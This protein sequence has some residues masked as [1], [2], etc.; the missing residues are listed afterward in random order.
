[1]RLQAR[2]NGAVRRRNGCGPRTRERHFALGLEYGAKARYAAIIAAAVANM[3]PDALRLRMIVT[4]LS[5]DQLAAYA[6]VT[7]IATRPEGIEIDTPS[8]AP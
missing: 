3:E 4:G 1:M 7:V 2:R 6:G 8:T 5:L